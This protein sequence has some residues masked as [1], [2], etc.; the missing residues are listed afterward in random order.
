[1]VDHESDL[2]R[3]CALGIVADLV[4]GSAAFQSDDGEVE[5][6]AVV[7]VLPVARVAD[8][9]LDPLVGLLA[10]RIQTVAVV[11]V[12]PRV[13]VVTN[14]NRAQLGTELDVDGETL[15]E[16]FGEHGPLLD[17]VGCDESSEGRFSISGRLGPAVLVLQ[18]SGHR[19][20]GVHQLVALDGWIELFGSLLGRVH[21]D[22]TV[23]SG[24]QFIQLLLF[25]SDKE[26]FCFS[27]HSVERVSCV[28]EPV[29]VQVHVRLF[30]VVKVNH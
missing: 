17:L 14:F 15:E 3:R 9:E 28:T 5:R 4:T 20:D 26:Y 22:L 2:V 1:V 11:E 7:D 29:T 13:S 8:A 10:L 21:D 19:A 30:V 27:V 6:L 18:G 24:S 16:V 23:E 12:G 25:V